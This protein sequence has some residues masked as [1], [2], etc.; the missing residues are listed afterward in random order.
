MEV[1]DTLLLPS[2][3]SLPA[4]SSITITKASVA[5]QK[6]SQCSSSC[7]L[8]SS[9]PSS[10][11]TS[12]P[13]TTRA[14]IEASGRG[15]LGPDMMP[16]IPLVPVQV[17]GGRGSTITLPRVRG[18]PKGMPLSPSRGGGAFQVRRGMKIKRLG[19]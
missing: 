13:T 14:G 18:R 8:S 16:T 3:A 5:Q 1:E 19:M 9:S 10:T 12:G 7:S 2:L 15:V 17:P 6:S 4:S 11:S